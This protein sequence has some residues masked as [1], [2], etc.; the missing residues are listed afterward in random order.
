MRRGFR[1]RG[2]GLLFPQNLFCVITLLLRYVVMICDELS[3]V[4]KNF[5]WSSTLGS[6]REEFTVV[7]VIGMF[8]A[9]VL[10]EIYYNWRVPLVNNSHNQFTAC[11][12]F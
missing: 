2:H 3:H 9:F 7:L 6:L 11:V 5:G 4:K 12:S 10:R 1:D 8:V